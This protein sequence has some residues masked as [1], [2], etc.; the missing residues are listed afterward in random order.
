M[1]PL[2]RLKRE[3][4]GVPTHDFNQAVDRREAGQGGPLHVKGAAPALTPEGRSYGTTPAAP[5][6][7]KREMVERAAEQAK[8]ERTNFSANDLHS[9]R[10]GD[11]PHKPLT[12]LK[13]E[14]E[15]SGGPESTKSAAEAFAKANY[16]RQSDNSLRRD[17]FYR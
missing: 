1:S 13:A 4:E 14:R 12:E 15:S 8:A 5:D 6:K 17:D 9:R 2:E 7:A 16:D 3:R 10:A 11:V